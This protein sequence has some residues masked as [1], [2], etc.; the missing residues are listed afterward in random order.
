M[1]Q[2][3]IRNFL[4]S[5]QFNLLK[6]HVLM[7]TLGGL[8][9]RE[10]L[11]FVTP[12][13]RAAAARATEVLLPIGLLLALVLALAAGIVRIQKVAVG[14]YY[15]WALAVNIFWA[16]VF[17]IMMGVV[18]WRSLQHKEQR[19]SYRF[20]TRLDVPM[21]VVYTDA[22]GQTISKE[23]YARN[24]NRCGVAL[25]LDDEIA[26]GTLVQIALSLPGRTIQATGK[27]VNKQV[28]KLNGNGRTKITSGILF[29]KI[30]SADQDEISKY[31]FWE[32]APKESEVLRL[33]AR[34]QREALVPPTN[35]V[36]PQPKAEKMKAGK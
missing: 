9:Q 16:V 27:V 28:H 1:L 5:E 3:G 14:G 21:R 13:A 19:A 29:D 22:K 18:V 7:R 6:M 11:F 33:T 17:L 34:S 32:I 20:P 24:L 26:N 15:F 8:F 35:G 25:M 36:A 10:S 30:A 4:L 31:L 2:G 23:E 12:K